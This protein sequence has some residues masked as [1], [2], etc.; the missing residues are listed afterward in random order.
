MARPRPVS[1]YYPGGG[2]GHCSTV[3][4]AIARGT[5]HLLEVPPRHAVHVQV[6]IL[7]EGDH[8]ADLIRKGPS[9]E[10]RWSQRKLDCP[11]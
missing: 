9:V 7:F 1:V 6:N 5:L 8:V 4:G 2:L 10:I 3:K 11:K